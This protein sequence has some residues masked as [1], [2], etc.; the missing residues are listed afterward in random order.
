MTFNSR[1]NNEKLSEYTRQYEL[2]ME[3]RENYN[4]GETNRKD[5]LEEIKRLNKKLKT[6]LYDFET[7][8]GKDHETYDFPNDITDINM[9]FNLLLKLT[10]NQYVLKCFKVKQNASMET[11]NGEKE[12][13]V[14]DGHIWVISD[15]DSIGRINDYDTRPQYYK[16]E[17]TKLVKEHKSIIIITDFCYD[18][19][20][21]PDNHNMFV[22][23]EN[24]KSFFVKGV[25]SDL[26]CY[27][28]NDLLG[29]AVKKLSKYI[30]VYGGDTENISMDTILERINDLNKEECVLKPIF[31]NAEEERF[32]YEKCQEYNFGMTSKE[33]R[34]KILDMMGKSRK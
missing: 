15:K 23:E 8:L 19:C 33:G 24:Y 3:L 20:V 28:N 29:I 27:Y 31:R 1:I 7:D 17:F 22:K 30:D 16:N 18:W 10:N 11:R 26:R 4:K 32:F 12:Y 13:G 6:M 14:I 2:L 5:I 9:I 21:L 25:I 34:Q